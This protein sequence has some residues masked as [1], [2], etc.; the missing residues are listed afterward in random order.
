M[1]T[2]VMNKRFFS[3]LHL[4][5]GADNTWKKL[6]TK[7]IINSQ[8]KVPQH[9]IPEHEVPDYVEE[10]STDIDYLEEGVE[11]KLN[12]IPSSDQ[13]LEEYKHSQSLKRSVLNK[14]ENGVTKDH[15]DKD[16][17]VKRDLLV[18]EFKEIKKLQMQLLKNIHELNVTSQNLANFISKRNDL[19]EDTYGPD[20]IA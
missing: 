19:L 1:T 10:N 7:N 11:P 5:D 12:M 2:D 3:N 13:Q 18:R 9:E 16:D 6:C 15:L 17:I 4:N 8:Y 20:Y 14:L